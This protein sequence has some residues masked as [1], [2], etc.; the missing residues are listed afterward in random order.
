MH[1]DASFCETVFPAKPIVER[2][3]RA[4]HF[5]NLSRKF[6]N[7]FDYIAKEL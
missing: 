3:L 2:K 7:T 5:T 6:D 1:S 4:A